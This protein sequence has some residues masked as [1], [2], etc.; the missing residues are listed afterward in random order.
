MES[1]A[2]NK[3]KC[4]VGVTM[5]IS[6][7][8]CGGAERVLKNMTDFWVRQ[9]RPVT[10]ITLFTKELDFFVLDERISRIDLGLNNNKFTFFISLYNALSVLGKLRRAIK[11][12]GNTNIISFISRTNILTLMASVLLPVKV[13]VSERKDPR[14]R[15]QGLIIGG[16]RRFL[17]PRAA[18]VVLQTKVVKNE[19]AS[20]FISSE[21][22]SVIPN[23]VISSDNEGKTPPISFAEKYVVA[24]G[25]LVPDKGFHLLLEIFAEISMEFS[26]L[27]LV[28]IGEGPERI[29]LEKMI[30]DM[31]LNDRVELP[32]FS[33][34]VKDI[35][36][37]AEC[38][39]LSS[40]REGFP[41]VLLEAMS[42]GKAVVSFDC[43]SGPAEIIEN[44]VTGILVP[45][46]DLAAFA[47]ATRFLLL[48]PNKR[49]AIGKAAKA[50]VQE[51]FSV[52][53]IMQ[54]WDDLLDGCAENQS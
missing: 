1:H 41:N 6:S 46:K 36:E 44:G 28:I 38:F 23:P 24:V 40:L 26:D 18:N 33:E 12:S 19:W 13:V 10:V 27:S 31:Q 7:L 20:G 34:N 29:R 22:I 50:S 21:K 39:M 3:E 37:H 4:K 25:R 52:P 42:C 51:R 16:L 32:G 54:Q 17:Y 35:M 53:V 43:P 14:G 30:N 2:R 48:D 45:E 49:S 8:A 9:G 5:V 11:K 47:A 15:R